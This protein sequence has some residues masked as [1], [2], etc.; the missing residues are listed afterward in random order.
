LAI[1]LASRQKDVVVRQIREI[2]IHAALESRQRSGI[3]FGFIIA[4]GGD[5]V[6]LGGAHN[7]GLMLRIQFCDHFVNFGVRLDPGNSGEG[8]IG[9]ICCLYLVL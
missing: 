5:Q 2:E 9:H 7:S 3:G 8:V 1:V 4:R 6:L